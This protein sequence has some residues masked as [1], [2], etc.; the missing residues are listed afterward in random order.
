MKNNLSLDSQ[1]MLPIGSTDFTEELDFQK[2]WLAL[3]R[4]WWVV[5]LTAVTCTSLGGIYALRQPKIYQA[6]GQIIIKDDQ[7][8]QL[9]GIDAKTGE[10]KALTQKS[11]P[12]STEAEVLKSRPVLA[13][14]ASSLNLKNSKG[15]LI[16]AKALSEKLTVKPIAGTDI[17]RLMY[18]SEQRGVAT[19]V[20]NQVMEAY[21]SS[22]IRVNQSQ[23]EKARQFI[24]AELKLKEVV[25]HQAEDELRRFREANGLVALERETEEAVKNMGLL[26]QNIDSSTAL[27]SQAEARVTQL[28]NQV[29]MD[30]DTALQ[31]NAL[32]Q[33]KTV[34]KALEDWRL[35]QAELAK[36]R[37]IYRDEAPEIMV[38]MEQV[39]AAAAILNNQT[40][41]VTGDPIAVSVDRLQLSKT[42][43][44][45]V[46]DLAKAEVEWIS[47]RQGLASLS[48][49][50][51]QAL[52]KYRSIPSLEATQRELQRQ[53]DAAQTTYKTLLTKLQ[54]VQVAKNQTVGNARIVSNAILSEELAGSKIFLL[55]LGS[56][57]SGL[58]VGIALAFLIDYADRSV[59]TLKEAKNLLPY[60]VLG[61]IPQVD[62]LQLDNSDSHQPYLLTQDS[63]HFSAQ[64]AYQMLQ[65]NLRFLPQDQSIRSIIVTSAMRQEGKSTVAA[66]L[67]MA[68]AQGQRRVLLVDADMRHSCQHHVWG[69]SNQVGLSNLLVGQVQMAAAVTAMRSNLHVLTA[70]TVP[71]NPLVLLDSTT[72]AMWVERF[73]EQYDFVIFDAPALLGTADSA[74]L[75]RMVDGSLVVLRLGG[76]DA[77][78]VRAMRQFINQSGQRVL[79]LVINDVDVKADRDGQ[80][81]TGLKDKIRKNQRIRTPYPTRPD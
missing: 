36:Q 81:Y 24:E 31:I 61:M 43:Q 72:M 33:S 10:I 27:L 39:R 56:G 63:P 26:N 38:L 65:A 40:Q 53:V 22:N 28:R 12:L 1:I 5:A 20:I 30:V 47:L 76:V 48:Q 78:P 14:V 73:T 21:I 25:V 3:Q 50:R 16:D 9:T 41:D 77:G 2:Y 62:L 60:P 29:G 19:Q 55:L 80:F 42:Q 44:D 51:S 59:K 75:N 17:L 58:L 49:S 34:Q 71:P 45:L 46:T 23:A 64:E 54:E 7:S 69:L 18:E 11:D 67:A 74:V 8:A 6:N 35:A 52:S 4:R 13:A 70:G 68:M 15:T 66:N 37:T 79:G 32:N 57:V